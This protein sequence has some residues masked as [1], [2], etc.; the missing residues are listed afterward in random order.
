MYVGVFLCDTPHHLDLVGLG[1]W[2][3]YLFLLKRYKTGKTALIIAAGMI[4]PSTPNI[5]DITIIRIAVTAIIVTIDIYF[6][7]L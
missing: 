4:E 5:L 3:G 2:L 7:I 6:L 1:I